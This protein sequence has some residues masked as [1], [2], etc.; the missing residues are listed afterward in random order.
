MFVVLGLA[1]VGSAVSVFGLRDLQPAPV[2]ERPSLGQCV[3][4]QPGPV[5]VGPDVT[6]VPALDDDVPA[7][8]NHLGLGV[9][10][11]V[12]LLGRLPSDQVWPLLC[13]L[14]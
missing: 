5:D 3:P 9:D 11:Q 12:D 1:N 2:V 13:L 10:P 14:L 4:V 8:V 6:L 7:P